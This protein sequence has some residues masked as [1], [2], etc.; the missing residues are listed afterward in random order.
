MSEAPNP[1]IVR[2]A[3]VYGE[4][5]TPNPAG[6]VA[7]L[8]RQLQGYTDG[9]L[10]AA[11]DRLL[12]DRATQKRAWPAFGMILGACDAARREIR[13]EMQYGQVLAFRQAHKPRTMEDMTEEERQALYDFVDAVAD[14]EYE[15]FPEDTPN[16]LKLDLGL[17]ARQL[18]K[19]AITMRERRGS[20]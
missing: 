4:P 6:F 5:D 17:L 12:R 20:Q 1:L 9:E 18:R 19:M 11:V 15:I 8:K 3:S 16:H 7:E 13:A 2:L 10:N 14:G